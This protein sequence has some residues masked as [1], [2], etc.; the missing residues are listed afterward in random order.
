MTCGVGYRVWL[1]GLLGVAL[2]AQG[3]NAA[4]LAARHAE[5][6]E[7]LAD[8]P[9]HQPLYLESR[10]SG[11]R[12]H[13]EVYAELAYP[14]LQLSPVL[15]DLGQWCDLLILHLNVKGCQPRTGSVG[16]G[17]TLHVGKKQEQSL[18]SAYPFSFAYRVRASPNFLQVSFHAAQG[19]LGTSDYRILVEAMPLDGRRSFV[20]LSYAYDYG[21]QAR[22][23]MRAYL[24]SGGR[25]KVGFS[26]VG[27]GASG[28]PIYQGGVRGI[29]ERNTM[30]YYL[31]I[32][33]YMA[34]L[35]APPASRIIRRLETWHD[36]VERYPRQLRELE[37][38]TYL[39]IK[40]REIHRQQAL[41]ASVSV[42]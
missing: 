2:L 10:Q 22:L 6:R 37:R 38:S 3:Q 7:R 14:Y 4:S 29:I 23:A 36:G 11:E 41:N 24:A 12:L 5:L 34:S 32:E 39:R 30:R 1:L 8:N 18:A 19:P 33:A 42:P 9:F 17:L 15:Q 40:Q 31:A 26:I 20:H 35:S 27:Q 16:P 21:L 25:D 13:G 28:L